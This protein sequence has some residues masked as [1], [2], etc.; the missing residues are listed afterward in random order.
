MFWRMGRCLVLGTLVAGWLMGCGPTR[1]LLRGPM[2]AAP[3]AKMAQRHVDMLDRELAKNLTCVRWV[4]M[5]GAGEHAQLTALV[6]RA[7][8][9]GSA[10]RVRSLDLRVQIVEPHSGKVLERYEVTTSGVGG[11]A[12]VA[13]GGGVVEGFINDA[14]EE[15]AEEVCRR[16]RPGGA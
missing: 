13:F 6:T 10:V 7:V 1:R 8:L 15:L 16:L 4:D 2:V 9:D 5:A 11:P 12:D 3:G 14:A